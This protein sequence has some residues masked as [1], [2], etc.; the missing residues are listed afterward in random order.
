[1][2]KIKQDIL[3]VSL[4]SCFLCYDLSMVQC[5]IVSPVDLHS[6]MS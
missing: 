2:G 5:N 1:M 4:V 3:T 6:F